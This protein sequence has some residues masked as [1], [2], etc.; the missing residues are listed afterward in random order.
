[1]LD[2]FPIRVSEPEV[3]LTWVRMVGTGASVPTEVLGAGV[4]ITRTDVGRYLLTWLDNPGTFAG[5]TWGLNATTQGDIKGHTVT[6]SV[7]PLT[8]ST[9]TLEIDL[10]DSA[11]AAEDL[12]ALEWLTLAI[13][14]KRTGV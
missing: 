1:M 6:A 7:Y 3:Y 4:T 5:F 10:W 2:A 13:A 12:E 11:F 14:F 9:Y 8:A